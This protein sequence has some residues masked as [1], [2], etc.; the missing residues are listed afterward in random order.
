MQHVA[1]IG[2][3][4]H[5]HERFRLEH[6]YLRALQLGE[7]FFIQ[8]F[9]TLAQRRRVEPFLEHHFDE[10]DPGVDLDRLASQH[11]QHLGSVGLLG[12]QLEGSLPGGDCFINST[13]LVFGFSQPEKDFRIAGIR[14]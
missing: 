9:L 6:H 14:V 8:Q 1:G 7:C 11:G 4:V 3:F 12:R 10:F 13:K 2:T 5:P